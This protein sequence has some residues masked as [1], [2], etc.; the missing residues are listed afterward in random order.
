MCGIESDTSIESLLVKDVEKSYQQHQQLTELMQ[1]MQVQHM[2][3]KQLVPLPCAVD[4]GSSSVDSSALMV[5][6]SLGE[7]LYSCRIVFFR[8]VTSDTFIT[9]VSK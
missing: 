6:A 5:P 2:W 9:A 3:L 7:L 8:A 4:N 1:A